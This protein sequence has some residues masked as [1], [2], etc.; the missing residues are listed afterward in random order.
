MSQ[1]DPFA[2]PDSDRTFMMP[3]PGGRAPRRI[4][5]V[6]TASPTSTDVTGLEALTPS[7]GFGPLLGAASPLLNLVPQ[8]RATLQHP[9]PAELREAMAQG[10]RS[11][12]SRAKGAGI[13]PE[14][15]IAARYA[16]CTLLDETA[17]STPWGGSGAWANKSLLV[18]FHN[19][20]WG[21]KVF[22]VARQTCG[23]CCR[24]S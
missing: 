1:E 14:K 6:A 20:T 21:G 18:L 16:L 22:P 4:E 5:T 7:G 13:S 12:E 9:N 3:S 8:L 19:E 11:F 23:K 2:L 15:V 17:A 24:Q 10:I